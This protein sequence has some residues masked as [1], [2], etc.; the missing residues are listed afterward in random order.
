MYVVGVGLK[1]IYKALIRLPR[2]AFSIPLLMSM[3]EAF[4]VAFLTLI[5]L[6]YTK[7][8]EWSSLVPGPKAISSSL[9]IMDLTSLTVSYHYQLYPD[10]CEP[11]RA[12]H[13][14]AGWC[15]PPVPPLLDT[16]LPASR[17]S[18]L[19]SPL[20]GAS[21]PPF[22]TWS[23]SNANDFL[24]EG[25]PEQCFS[26]WCPGLDSS[27]EDALVTSRAATLSHPWNLGPRVTC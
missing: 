2:E 18:I 1:K 16:R 27:L 5:K 13:M 10:S 23:S 22:V 3:S 15:C 14:L 7:A 6:C 4:S 8:L 17:D 9:E 12:L 20:P 25:A 19:F 21:L 26:R 11:H 24:Q